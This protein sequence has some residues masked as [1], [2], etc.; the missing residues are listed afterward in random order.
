V[1]PTTTPHKTT[2]DTKHKE[3]LQCVENK[4][5]EFQRDVLHPFRVNNGPCEWWHYAADKNVS[6]IQEA[7]GEFGQS[8][9]WIA[10]GTGE[11]WGNERGESNPLQELMHNRSFPPQHHCS[12]QSDQ[13]SHPEDGYSII[14]F[15]FY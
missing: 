3:S 4:V 8:Q 7:L 6:V 11:S 5:M 10:D 12:N 9:L 15:I 13:F 1:K 2:H 14:Y